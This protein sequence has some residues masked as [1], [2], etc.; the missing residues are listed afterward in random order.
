MKLF[1]LEGDLAAI[2]RAQ[3]EFFDQP[4][5]QHTGNNGRADYP[6]HMER[7]EP[8]HFLDAVP[9]D[10]LRFYKYYPERKAYQQV[11]E[12]VGPPAWR[13]YYACRGA[14]PNGRF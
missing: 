11:A 2:Y 3:P 4:Y 8:E 5:G 10:D 12:Q 9:A 7:L 6:V 14:Q 1:F 13:L